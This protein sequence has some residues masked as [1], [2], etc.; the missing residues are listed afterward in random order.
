MPAYLVYKSRIC[1][2]LACWHVHVKGTVL[3]R[4]VKN[5]ASIPIQM[6]AYQT[7]KHLKH[8]PS[9]KHR[10][11]TPGN[12]T[13]ILHREFDPDPGPFFVGHFLSNILRVIYIRSI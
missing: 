12:Y 5:P 4:H 8:F 7:P 6:P 1:Q 11:E 9:S 2:L 10:T 3:H 13:S